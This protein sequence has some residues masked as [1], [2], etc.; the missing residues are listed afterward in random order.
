MPVSSLSY[1]A[2]TQLLRNPLI[3]KMKYILGVYD[4]KMS[5]SGMIG[6]AGHE[7]L[8][9]YYGGN[10]DVPVPADRTEA[11]ALAK[12]TGLTYLAEFSD[13]YI[14]YGK[15]GSREDM[16]KGYSQAMD[17]YFAEEPEY[18]EIVLC[19]EKLNGELRT[20]DGD[21]LPLPA[22]GI[23]DLVHK[24]KDGKTEI[25]DTKF[26]TRFTDYETEDYIKIIQ[27]QFMYHLLLSAKGIQAE[28]MLF[29]EIKRT[30]NSNG[31]AGKPQ[32]RDWAVPFDHEPYRIIF[33][34]LYRDVAKFL[35][36]D[37]IFLPNLSD[38]FDGEHAGL[39]YAQGLINA[40]MSD[41]E[42]MHKVRDIAFASKK[43]VASRL[44][45][46][47]NQHLLPEE[48]IKLKLL[49]FGIPVEPDETRN[50]GSVTQY[51]FKVS[52]GVRMQTIKKHKDDIAHAIGA[53]GEIRILA[54][55]PG[56]SLV[57]VE[58]ENETK[59][60]RKLGKEHLKLGTLSIP[61]GI[62]VGD[63]CVSVPLNE[64]PHLLIAGT[65]GSGKSTLLHNIITALT[66]QMTPE[67]MELVLIDPKRVELAPFARKPHLTGKII[68]VY[69]GALR[70]LKSLTDAMEHRYRLLEKAG[71]RDIAEY[72]ASKRN[73]ENRLPYI[74]TV[75]DEFADLIL[76]AGI[77]E[78]KRKN[79][80][81]Q[82]KSKAWL[83]KTL[84]KRGR[85]TPEG[86]TKAELAETLEE[87]DAQDEM[88]R[89]DAS[90]EL[91]MVRLAQMARAIGI[92]LIIATQRPSTDVITGLIK[93]N[94]PT[95]IAL[96]TASPTDSEVILGK[97]G[98]EK[99]AGKGDML[100]LH[101]ANRGEIR[102]QGF[103][104]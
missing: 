62:N 30:K 25:I 37:P 96:T 49:E 90:I 78:K 89:P 23:P 28:R 54:P 73:P 53:K 43:F 3:F 59:A 47:E 82:H 7:A 66:K 103:A 70:K 13:A 19:E 21:L 2:L 36:N 95:R 44:D 12:E 9:T 99:L 56:T 98:A 24:R 50:G 46:A 76:R 40:D 22:S 6:R 11:I 79:G 52:A 97:R 5:V 63:E 93:A 8:K 86:M 15:T 92:H 104:M 77:E 57:G 29:R 61:I 48:K 74:V 58:V 68:Y 69:D 94:F 14:E 81:Y 65:T 55:I 84:E 72:N 83:L 17:F 87:L 26:V 51:R 38:P 31:D 39:M 20:P 64:M 42:V 45:R 91:L 34:N 102:L 85:H 27:S 80:G 75:V 10:P 1:S 32:I 18:D 100:F 60:V 101:P 35:S 16:L 4:A 71:K 41:V 67:E 33:Y 88:N